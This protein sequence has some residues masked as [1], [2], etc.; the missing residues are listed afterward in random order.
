[1][2]REGSNKVELYKTETRVAYCH[3]AM[4]E[5]LGDV[6]DDFEAKLKQAAKSGMLRTPK[7]IYEVKWLIKTEPKVTIYWK[8]YF[9]S[10]GVRSKKTV[11]MVNTRY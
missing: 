10:C 1:M 8:A 4:L 11:W 6:Q 5:K 3:A 7:K 2:A 9:K